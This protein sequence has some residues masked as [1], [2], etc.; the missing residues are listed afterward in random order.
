MEI[1]ERDQGEAGAGY[2][3]MREISKG[4]CAQVLLCIH[5][6]D[7]QT[8]KTGIRSKTLFLPKTRIHSQKA[9]PKIME[10]DPPRS[11][12]RRWTDPVLPRTLQTSHNA[13]NFQILA[14]LDLRQ[15][16]EEK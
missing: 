1:W 14:F 2:Q 15:S 11:L 5:S 8:L 12:G 7:H 3:D 16:A 10:R 9:L 13:Q 4:V 6:E